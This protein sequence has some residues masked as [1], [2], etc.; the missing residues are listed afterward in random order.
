MLFAAEKYHLNKYGRPITGETYM[1][2]EHGTVP[3]WLYKKACKLMG[4][5]F[6]KAG[7]SLIAERNYIRKFFS[8][9]D[10]EAL[11]FGYK[12]YKNLK[13]FSEVEDKNHK[14]PAW[15]KAWKKR[16][17]KKEVPIQF[18][19]VP[20]QFEDLID[21]AWLIEELKWSSSFIVI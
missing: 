1:A 15:K 2:M 11:E 9:T 13:T 3:K 17:A 16:G 7:I 12:E 4:V 20:I 14:E 18:E 6:A 21:E 5:G 19:E 8:Q 10:I